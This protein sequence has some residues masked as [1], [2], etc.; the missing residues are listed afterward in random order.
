MAMFLWKGGQEPPDAVLVTGGASSIATYTGTPKK[1]EIEVKVAPGFET[2]G[3]TTGGYKRPEERIPEENLEES[4]PT[5]E[6][7]QAESYYG[8]ILARA[9]VRA[10]EMVAEANNSDG[11]FSKKAPGKTD[12][13]SA[14]ASGKPGQ[15]ERPIRPTSR[16]AARP[17]MRTSGAAIAITPSR[18][19]GR[20]LLMRNG[21]ALSGVARSRDRD[22][23]GPVNIIVEDDTKQRLPI[24][25]SLTRESVAL[26]LTED[27]P[28]EDS[29]PTGLVINFPLSEERLKDER[30]YR[31]VG[32][33]HEEFEAIFNPTPTW[34]VA[35]VL[36]P[37]L[38]VERAWRKIR[39]CGYD[40]EM[41]ACRA[42]RAVKGFFFKRRPL[43]AKS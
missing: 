22:D 6:K 3:T 8:E 21:G 19:T 9:N 28:D 10:A 1:V 13:K 15:T 37:R 43:P 17:S 18:P 11:I 14:K 20:G 41:V 40:T 24:L 26:E 5:E 39:D 23:D 29:K 12:N 7:P 27:L 34:S 38:N 4:K 16:G 32:M 30:F 35:D 33:T 31:Q 2:S 42:K 25:M 36:N